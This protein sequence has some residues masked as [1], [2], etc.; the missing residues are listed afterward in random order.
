MTHPKTWGADAHLTTSEGSRSGGNP[1]TETGGGGAVRTGSSRRSASSA[2]L[3]LRGRTCQAKLP[4]IHTE[5]YDKG[6]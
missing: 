3:L 1:R 6:L 4:T 5:G 2:V